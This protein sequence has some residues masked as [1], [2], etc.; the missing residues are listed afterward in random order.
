MLDKRLLF[1]SAVRDKVR[2]YS[3]LRPLAKPQNPVTG[4]HIIARTG[5]RVNPFTRRMFLTGYLGVN[6]MLVAEKTK[7]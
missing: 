6:Y 7:P 1:G 5:V 2:C 4:L 3:G